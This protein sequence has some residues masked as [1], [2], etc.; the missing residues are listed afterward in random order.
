L[1]VADCGLYCHHFVVL[2]ALPYVRGRVTSFL[3]RC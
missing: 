2:A 1:R 3:E